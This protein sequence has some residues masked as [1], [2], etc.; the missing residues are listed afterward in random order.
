M[1]GNQNNSARIFQIHRE[2]ASLHQEDKP[3]VQLLGSFK[4]LWNELEMYRPHTTDATILRKR[5]KED[6]IFQLLASLSPDFEDLRSHILMNLEL[7]TFKS[8]CATIQ[9]EE[10]RRKVMTRE[11]GVSDTR[12]YQ[13]K[14]LPKT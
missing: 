2:V 1:Y 11:A 3:F 12:A 10:I 4:N 5:T 14:L 9:H 7:P 8:V 13:T 6:K